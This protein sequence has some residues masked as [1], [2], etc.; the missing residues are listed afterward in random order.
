VEAFREGLGNSQDVPA[1]PDL[2]WAVRHFAKFSG[3]QIFAPCCGRLLFAAM[4]EDPR[5][6]CNLAEKD[7]CNQQAWSAKLR[8]E[9]G[10]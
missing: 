5:R 7:R 10:A 4:R 6:S 2:R 8:R 1:R 3:L 9:S